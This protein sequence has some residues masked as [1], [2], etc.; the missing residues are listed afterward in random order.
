[1]GVAVTVNTF[2]RDDAGYLRWLATHPNGYVINILRSLNASTARLHHTSCRTIGGGQPPA[3]RTWTGPYL[4]V[5]A[6]AV[7]VLDEWAL[8]Y[9]SANITRCGTCQPSGSGLHAGAAKVM[10]SAATT[11]PPKPA[12]RVVRGQATEIGGP[13]PDRPVVEAWAEEYIRFERRPVEQEQLRAE[14]RRRL[15]QLTATPDQVLHAT[16]LGAKHPAADVENL[17][18]YYIDDTGASF[19]NAARYG[20]RFELATDRPPSPT[21]RDFAYGYRY[22]LLPRDTACRHWREERELASWDWVDLAA[23]AGPKKL[24]Q[25]WLGLRRH[26]VHVAGTLRAS[27]SPFAVRVT[28]RPPQGVVPRLGYLLKGIVDGVVCALQAHTDRSSVVEVATRVSNIIGATPDE[29]E[30][31]LVQ[32]D[33]AV[34]G[35]VPR[36]L[37]K[38]GAGVIWAPSDD[39]CVA[40]E[41]LA[42]K[43]TGPTW[44]FR[45]RVVE[46][47]PA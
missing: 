12:R 28:I 39:L 23:F 11:P 10:S 17:A 19:A 20:L 45:G 36:L 37:H 18:L 47:V 29:I 35:V 22:E 9:A 32:Q 7:G 3:G 27:S 16:F 34:L 15:G 31:L 5:C 26:H 33:R 38:R 41:L 14:I 46:L 2:D 8:E 43:P 13:W 21:G 25:V 24:E 30:T 44:S 4:K 40:G 1:L 6:D 42:A